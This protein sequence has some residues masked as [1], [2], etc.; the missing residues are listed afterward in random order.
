M[1]K[2]LSVRKLK[3]RG[4][5]ELHVEIPRESSLFA[6]H[7]PGRP[8]LP[9]VVQLALVVRAFPEMLGSGVGLTGIRALKLRRPVLPGDA[10]H[11]RVEDPEVDGWSRFELRRE[12]E[13]VSGGEVRFTAVEDRG[14]EPDDPEPPA[15]AD[16]PPVEALLP[17]APPARFLR[18][19]LSASA[20]EIV[21]VAE[22]PRR[23]P[24]S[25][26]RRLPAVFAI[27]AAAQAAAVLEALSRREEASGPR[28]GYLVGVRAARFGVL[29]LAPGQRLRVTAR[30]TGSAA[31][32]SIYEIGVGPPGREIVTGSISTFLADP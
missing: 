10:L 25:E 13:R 11:L 15:A 16:I 29:D 26:E 28:I 1:R 2:A 3:T 14:P 9:G 32:L 21:A 5:R 12:E 20:E 30:R 19:I 7:F 24:L 8:I 4:N 27:E 17:H 31:A 22:F 18:S 23:H 6:G